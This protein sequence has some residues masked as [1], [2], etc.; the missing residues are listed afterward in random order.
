MKF[1]TSDSIFVGLS[2]VLITSLSMLLYADFNRKI[3]AG[4]AKQIG[5]IT[6]KR[7]MAQRKYLA[8]VVWEDIEQNFPVY[9]NDSIRTAGES[10][11]VIHLS[12]GTDINIDE[13]SMIMLSTGENAININFEHGTI[14]ANR[15]GVAGVDIAAINIKSGRH[16]FHRQEQYPADTDGQ[17]GAGPDC[18]RGYGPCLVG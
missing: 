1:L 7:Q 8:Q 4:D 5:T 16:C 15:S 11:A 18:V 2:A 14:S 13:N 17:P 10:E 3:E 6:Y 9:N 12:D